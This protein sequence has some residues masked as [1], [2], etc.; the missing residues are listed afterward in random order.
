M[1]TVK[2]FLIIF[3]FS[4]FIK[5]SSA[6]IDTISTQKE[7]LEQ[8]K[9]A[10][11]D[12]EILDESKRK[13]LPSTLKEISGHVYWKGYLYCHEDSGGAASVYVVNPSSGQIVQTI[14]LQGITNIDWEDIT[15]DHTHFYICDVGNNN[16]NRNNLKIYKFSKSLLPSPVITNT[17]TVPKS[18]IK[19]IKYTY[20]GQAGT[21]RE[22]DCEAVAYN[23]GKLHLFTKNWI[24]STCRHYTLPTRAGTYVAKLRESYNTGDVKITGADFGAYDMLVLVGYEVQG[25]GNIVVFLDYGFDGTYY[26]LNT[27]EVKKLTLG[28]AGTYGQ[29]EG[30][31]M[32]NLFKGYISNEY[33][34]RKV[35]FFKFEV[36]QSIVP[37]NLKKHIEEYYKKTPLDLY[38]FA[39]PKEGTIRY[40]KNTHK[41]EGFDGT[42]WLPFH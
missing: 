36:V 27:G 4:C 19:E 10:K 7:D 13:T 20:E 30:I 22:Y 8:L 31:A 18:A 28:T 16:G 14:I 41:I 15:Q 40:N 26:Y 35:L 39:T 12:R 33:F 9:M 2:T 1:K 17:V 3:I 38:K 42:H 34:F 37:F 29:I 23:R 5:T 6:Q 21:S 32:K 24:G 25:V 11:S